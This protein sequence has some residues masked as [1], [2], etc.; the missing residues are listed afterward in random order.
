M[1]ET[2]IKPRRE[3]LKALGGLVLASMV[4]EMSLGQQQEASSKLD[5]SY[6]VEG[7]G[8][9]RWNALCPTCKS[10]A[11]DSWYRR[12]EQGRRNIVQMYQNSQDFLNRLSEDQRS[13]FYMFTLAYA[14][15][16]RE[17]KEPSLK[18]FIT[19]NGRITQEYKLNFPWIDIDTPT[20]SDKILI[21]ARETLDS[22]L[23]GK[24]INWNNVRALGKE[25]Y[26]FGEIG[27]RVLK[28]DNGELFYREG[29]S[30]IYSTAD[31][32]KKMAVD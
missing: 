28:Q 29:N 27:P 19:Q 30:N 11:T 18:I 4:P 6:L 7:I 1:V 32:K 22:D 17:T 12:E 10:N 3:F 16:G 21:Y 25:K 13:E 26:R 5:I 14:R 23:K 24:R 15:A 31:G 8:K 2:Q 20:H 9:E